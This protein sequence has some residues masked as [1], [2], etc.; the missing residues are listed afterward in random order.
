MQ[1]Q[2]AYSKE[3]KALGLIG[4][5]ISYKSKDVLLR[6][7]KTL[8]HPHL[9]TVSQLGHHVTPKT[10]KLLLERVQ[11]RLQEWFRDSS[12]IFMIT[13]RLQHLG[14][15]VIGRETKGK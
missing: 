8:V 15:M 14:I 6:L 10:I 11:H 5:T 2:Q 12:I 13:Y 1:C 4:R 7:Y 9:D 3:S